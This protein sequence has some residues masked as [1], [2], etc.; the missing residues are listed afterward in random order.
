[1]GVHSEKGSTM[2]EYAL[3]KGDALLCIG[4]LA[5]C[6]ESIN[7]KPS[8]IQFYASPARERR[9]ASSKRPERCIVAVRL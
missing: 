3:Y 7:V 8:T 5:D 6:A 9:I 2:T 1:M 4:N